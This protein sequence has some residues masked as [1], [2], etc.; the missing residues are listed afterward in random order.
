MARKAVELDTTTGGLLR[1]PDLLEA[2][3]AA[4]TPAANCLPRAG[5]DGKI[6]GAWVGPGVA[7]ASLPVAADGEVSAMKLV[8]A[9]D[10]RFA[11]PAVGGDLSGSALAAMVIRLQGRA[12]AATLPANAHVLTWN[13]A[14]S[15]W[16]PAPPT[17]GGALTVRTVDG[18]ATVANVAIIQVANGTLTNNGSGTVTIATGSG[19]GSNPPGALLALFAA[20]R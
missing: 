12:V 14:A 10:S 7:L 1:T 6:S 20:Y 13:N 16:E 4:T 19:G 3:E 18:A 11:D 15:R 9:D 2:T 5:G 17:G 8:R